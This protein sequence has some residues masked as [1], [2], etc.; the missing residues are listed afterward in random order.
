MQDTYDF[1]KYA[2][3]FWAHPVWSQGTPCEGNIG[4]YPRKSQLP[5]Q[6]AP[7]K[8]STTGWHEL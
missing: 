7:A 5:S 6:V 8:A 4:R 2:V 1:G 3:Y